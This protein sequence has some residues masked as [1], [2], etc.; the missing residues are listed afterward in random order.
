MV[1]TKLISVDPKLALSP[2][3]AAAVAE[4]RNDDASSFVDKG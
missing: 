2:N 3:L 1:G 4:L